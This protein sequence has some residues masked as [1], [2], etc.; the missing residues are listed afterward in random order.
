MSVAIRAITRLQDADDAPILG[1]GQ[2]GYVLQWDNGTGAFVAV[3]PSAGVV[4]HGAL[5]GLADDDHAQYALLAGRA[6]GQTL[7]GGTGANDDITIH[8]TSDATRTTS[9]VLLQPTAGYV[10]IG[11]TAPEYELDVDGVV[12][13]TSVHASS[14][15][16]GTHNTIFSA[17]GG[18][19]TFNGIV[20]F[21]RDVYGVEIGAAGLNLVGYLMSAHLAVQPSA[22]T[23]KAIGI[24][25]HAGQTANLVQWES[26]N[27]GTVYGVLDATGRLGIGTVA[28]SAQVHALLT[29]AATNAVANVVTIGHDTSGTAAA[30]FGAGLAFQLESSTTAAQNAARIQALWYEATHATF[31]GD[32]VGTAYDAGGEREG[33][34]V[35]GAGSAAAIGF[36]GATPAARIAHVADPAGGGTVDAEA[37]TAINSILATLETFGFHAT[38]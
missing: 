33:W 29:S 12:N 16:D 11:K 4:D 6:G 18:V 35:R 2:D 36:L 25:A 26:D 34:R 19:T 17:G 37:R 9:Y 21:T 13:A 10:G 32:L 7:Y 5:T 14:Y 3:E 24:R 38:S 15:R 27:G 1:V 30:G 23:T 8:G 20:R 22:A 31:K 28:P